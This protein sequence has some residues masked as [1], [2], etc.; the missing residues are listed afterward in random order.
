MVN[1]I[2]ESINNVGAIRLR[3]TAAPNGR[4]ALPLHYVNELVYRKPEKEVIAK[5]RN[6]D[7]F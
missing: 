3:W 6:R 2:F 5:T 4:Q 1:K 7:M